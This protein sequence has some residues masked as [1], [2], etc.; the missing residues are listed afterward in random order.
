[1][2]TP[3]Q[4]ADSRELLLFWVCGSD[5]DTW[6]HEAADLAASDETYLKECRR[7]ALDR[8]SE[9]QGR[10]AEQRVRIADV[11]YLF[12]PLPPLVDAELVR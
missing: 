10:V 9:Y 11:A 5:G 2:S 1:M 4:T 7:D 12:S 8:A 3:V 6:L